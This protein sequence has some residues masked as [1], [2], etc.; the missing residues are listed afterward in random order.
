[1]KP[2]MTA[3]L[4]KSA[5]ILSNSSRKAPDIQKQLSQAKALVSSSFKKSPTKFKSPVRVPMNTISISGKDAQFVGESLS[6]RREVNYQR[7]PQLSEA[8]RK[9][10]ETQ[11]QTAELEND[12][13]GA[14]SDEG[15]EG[16]EFLRRGPQFHRRCCR[17]ERVNDHSKPEW[18]PKFKWERTDFLIPGLNRKLDSKAKKPVGVAKMKELRRKQ[19]FNFLADFFDKLESGKM[20]G[21]VGKEY[22]FD[23]E[24]KEKWMK[25]Y[26]MKYFIEDEKD[27]Q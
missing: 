5:S 9:V 19:F 15:S 1:M 21:K 13:T 23:A 7:K 24:E 4:E 11:K 25:R 8:M 27:K 12:G 2:K 20:D 22:K 10:K 3:Q 6:T 26:F 17:E 18:K 14:T 16:S